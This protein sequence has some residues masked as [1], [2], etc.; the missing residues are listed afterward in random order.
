MNQFA[1]CGHNSRIKRS[2]T[3]LKTHCLFGIIVA[4]T[5]QQA[6]P[7]ASGAVIYRGLQNIAIPTDFAGVYLNIDD[8]TANSVEFTGWDINPFFGG[9][10]VGNS[11]A[12]QP[13][14]TGTANSDPII[15]LG[16]GAS[17]GGSLL[18]ST[19]Q[20]GS[21]GH[22]GAGSSRFGIGQ[23]AYL[24]FRFTT[25]GNIGP[26]FGWMRVVFTANTPGGLVKDWAYE[27]DGSSIRTGNVLQ[28]APLA[29]V[30]VVTLSGEA[31]QNSTLGPLL[32][33]VGIG[34]VISV[35]KTGAG[36]WTLS[37]AP[38]YSSLT[39][40][41][42]VTNLN[43][44]L[45]NA[46]ITANGGTLNV[47]ADATNS[48]VNANNAG[49]VSFRAGQTLA[50]LNIGAGGVAELAD[51]TSSVVLEGADLR[52]TSPLQGVPEPVAIALLL[53]GFA[54]LFSHRRHGQGRDGQ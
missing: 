34:N 24:G 7:F 36:I 32:T 9:V 1:N 14:R 13:A 33:N 42:G 47:N 46:T 23:E 29:G 10:G 30:S 39:T 18:Y 21:E 51:P 3:L 28:A 41:D 43:V 11:P 38:N 53:G 26:L 6:A 45:I 52:V 15:A 31:G 2:S 25:D 54:A 17:V 27:S 12:F 19:G 50:G 16:A 5:I 37:G 35:V 20:G 40:N 4:L 49:T 22:L 8:G 44:S 48:T